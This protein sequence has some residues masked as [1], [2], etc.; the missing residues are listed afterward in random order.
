MQ[1]L[2]LRAIGP[3][4]HDDKIV[5]LS[6][7]GQTMEINLEALASTNNGERKL[8]IK[9]MMTLIINTNYCIVLFL[10]FQVLQQLP[11]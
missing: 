5:S 6:A 2:S 11:L 3:E 7:K 9:N 4:S 1:D 10:Q 8:I